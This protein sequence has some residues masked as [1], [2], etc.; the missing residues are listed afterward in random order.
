[1]NNGNTHFL[2]RTDYIRLKNLQIGYNLPVTVTERVGMQAF[3]FYVGGFNLLTYAP[4]FPDFDPE[5]TSAAGTAYPLQ[6]IVNA[7]VTLTF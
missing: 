6:K 7:G 2:H 1:M 4:D 5:M 3:R